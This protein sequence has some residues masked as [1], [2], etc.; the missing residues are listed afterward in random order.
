MDQE[1]QQACNDLLIRMSSSEQGPAPVLRLSDVV[2]SL[3]VVRA[4][5]FATSLTDISYLSKL[6]QGDTRLLREDLNDCL[7]ALD[8]L[9]EAVA[10]LDALRP[11]LTRVRDLL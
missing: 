3:R 1:Q 5:L 2:T 4:G 10:E 6:R 9:H 7:K 11:E 8:H